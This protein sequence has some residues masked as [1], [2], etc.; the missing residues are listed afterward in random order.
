MTDPV[1]HPAHYEL[2]CGIEC[3][4]VIL[5]SQ[6][7]DATKGFCVGNAIKY[8]FRAPRKGGTE[9]HK[10]ASWYLNKLIEIEESEERKELVGKLEKIEREM[11]ENRERD[12]T[13]Y[14]VEKIAKKVVVEPARPRW[15]GLDD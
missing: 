8:L 5:S 15:E 14:D 11:E 1:N 10:K 6:G 7:I 4:D 9:D 12:I 2:P 13:T 3:F